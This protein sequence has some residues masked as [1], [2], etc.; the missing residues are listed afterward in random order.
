MED[1]TKTPF[2]K[3]SAVENFRDLSDQVLSLANQDIPRFEFLHGFLKMLKNFSGCDSVGIRMKEKEKYFLCEL[4]DD[5]KQTLRI[6]INQ[7]VQAQDKKFVPYSNDHSAL[8]LACRNV[9]LRRF[10]PALKCFT[11]RGSFWAGEENVLLRFLPKSKKK[12]KHQNLKVR[13]CYESIAL[14][15]IRT[16]QNSFG[17]LQL[18]SR[19]KNYFDERIVELYEEFAKISGIALSSQ[20]AQ[21]ALRERVKELNCLYGLSKL[22]SQPD[23]SLDEIF[24]STV[25]LIPP[26]WQ[27]P[28]ITC[29]RIVFRG[30]EYTTDHFRKTRWKQKAII[31]VKGIESGTCEVYYTQ[32]K[33]EIEE[34]PFLKEEKDL[35]IAIVALLGSIVEYREAEEEKA[36]LAAIVESSDDAII[37]KTLD[38][39]ITSWNEGAE[40]VYGYRKKEILGESINLIMIPGQPDEMPKILRRIKRGDSIDNYETKRIRKDGEKI[41]VSLSISPIKSLG[42][43]TTGVSTIAR[44]ITKQKKA[45]EALRESEWALQERVKELTC[46]YN[47]ALLAE[48]PGKSLEELLQGVAGLIPPAWQYPEI[49]HGRIMFDDQEYHSPGFKQGAQ[50]Q[51]A[52]IYVRGEKRGN[53][54][55]FYE[56]KMPEIYEGP[57]LKEER[58]LIDAI[59]KQ[60]GLIVER[61]EAEQEQMRLQEQLRH[62]D[63]LATIGQLAA[64]IAHELNEPLGNI[65]G[66]AQLAIKS[67]GISDQVEQDIA[68]I[69][70]ASLYAREI[71]KKLMLFARQ[72]PPKKTRVDLNDIV[73]EGIEFLKIRAA[74]EGVKITC[75]LSPKLPKI[76]ADSAQLNQ[77]LVN[78]V[79]NAIQAMPKG[80]TLNIKTAVR[81]DWLSLCVEDSGLGMSEEVRKNIFLP[82]YTTKDVGQGTGLGLSVV[83]GI[84]KSHG[85]TIDVVSREG[86]GSSFEIKL[87]IDKPKK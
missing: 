77:V 81:N 13:Q 47:L 87:P 52:G 78:L 61:R 56:K 51:T 37:G 72:T 75:H 53:I 59:G 62:A 29:A 64:G 2:H 14:I 68:K 54:E 69:V 40:R 63:R 20:F 82:F 8:E 9:Y 67:E 58:S 65:L 57:F 45:D 24:K 3:I 74:Q 12:Q 86:K 34:G 49:T 30:I 23:I 44:D 36:K 28:E 38:G 4:T 22:A 18:K 10:H 35:L 70:S 83:H 15:P 50:S 42:G 46:L 33:P 27:Y 80:G 85:G 76:T 26:A 60:V 7:C 84:V 43:M 79:V 11:K 21:A 25:K 39:I 6:Q 1:H 5:S 55:V 16:G 17:I 32:K 71:I 31:N 73:N 48:E 19:D 66:F 41:D